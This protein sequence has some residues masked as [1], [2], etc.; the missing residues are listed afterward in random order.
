MN[1]TLNKSIAITILTIVALSIIPAVAII[2]P[3]SAQQQYTI[4]ASSTY[5]HDESWI[6]IMVTGPTTL[7]E[8][9]IEVTIKDSGESVPTSPTPVVA[10]EYAPGVFV[11]YLGGPSVPFD[12]EY[13]KTSALYTIDVTP[14][15]LLGETLVLTVPALGFISTEVKYDYA[16]ISISFDRANY[17]P[18]SDAWIRLKIKDPNWNLDPT[19][20]DKLLPDDVPI[21]LKITT[22][23]G[24]M[25][26]IEGYLS[27]LTSS[28]SAEKGV[29]NGEFVFEF[30]IGDIEAFAGIQF[31]KDNI[32]EF[33]VASNYDP[34][35]KDTKSFLITSVAPRITLSGSFSDE[36][37]I[38]V[39]YPDKNLKS[40]S[41]DSLDVE[42]SGGIS[43]TFTLDET[44]ANTGIFEEDIDLDWTSTLIS[45]AK[46]GKS[47]E[48]KATL[49]YEYE[50][51]PVEAS[52]KLT[53]VASKLELAKIEY[54]RIDTLALK[55]EDPD[56]NDKKDSVE[57]YS[58][59]LS[60]DEYIDAV[61]L[62]KGGLA[63]LEVS[64]LKLPELSPVK[65]TDPSG[66]TLSLVERYEEPGIF[67]LK[68]GLSKL[69][70]TEDS[71][72]RIKLVDYTSGK[73]V[74]A[75][76]KVI[77]MV[78][79]VSTDRSTYP[80]VRD[81]GKSLKIYVYITD[82]EANDNPYAKNSIDSNDVSCKLLYYTQDEKSLCSVS[83]ILETDVDTG[84]FKGTVTLEPADL[85]DTKMINGRIRV[86]YKGKKAEAVFRPTSASL[87]VNASVVKYGDYILVRLTD[88]DMNLD[89]D[90]AEE[91]SVGGLNK[92]L[93]ET[94]KNTGVFEG[95]FLVA[96]DGD[97]SAD[98]AKTF[99]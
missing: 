87:F 50:N 63:F 15:E 95:T 13:Q 3:V 66:L 44:G 45:N 38:S 32:V 34:D 33:T 9:M 86:E 5:M 12:P 83:N 59:Q 24:T 74:I 30:S 18:S 73:E 92:P 46:Q 14:G 48:V 31:E 40:W 6:E 28:S 51:K 67:D 8:V 62:V 43:G 89:I 20:P 96:D 27:D 79:S 17:P 29:N 81:V 77:K 98:P 56:L 60:V 2:V 37:K 35:I 99:E 57:V 58:K 4:T 85:D 70:I 42:L 55:V 64:L 80:L 26:P 72:Y 71:W 52:I 65:V 75:D 97:V 94:G 22:A 39:N 90:S 76:F 84:V 25:D 53:P 69:D 82:P 7:S 19:S 41:K 36:I 49:I 47:I 78:I 16:P 68:I 11:A 61:K 88:A 10:T 91:I 93:K 21:K 23:G 1:K 54:F